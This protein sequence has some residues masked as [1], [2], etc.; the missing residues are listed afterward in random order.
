MASVRQ[1]LRARDVMTADPVCVGP[2]ATIRDL[3]RI[4]EEHEISGV[5][6]V[7]Q[8]GRIIGVVSKTD[9]IRRCAEGTDDIPPAYLFEILG[10]QGD[11]SE[12]S[13]VIPEPLI[14][15]E[16]FMTQDP[17][18]VAPD[19]GVTAV[20]RLMTERR[21]HR[22]VVADDEDFPVGIITSMDLLEAFARGGA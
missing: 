11:G 14:C 15:V 3:G 1:E 16:D 8:Q 20:A 4:F 21:V 22:V 17:I 6:V 5:P 13:E 2:S 10:E 9:L 12:P 18:T 19:V 7:D